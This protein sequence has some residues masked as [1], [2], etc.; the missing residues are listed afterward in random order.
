METFFPSNNSLEFQYF[1]A[2]GSFTYKYFTNFTP[3]AHDVG[4]PTGHLIRESRNVTVFQNNHIK[5]YT[6]VRIITYLFDR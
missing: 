6:S 2:S 3:P 1:T 4:L 5:P